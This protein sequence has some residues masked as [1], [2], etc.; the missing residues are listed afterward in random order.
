MLSRR[1]LCSAAAPTLV[2][3]SLA[4]AAVAADLPVSEEARELFR[5]AVEHA[6]ADTRGGYEQAYRAFKAAYA[7]SPSWKILGN[8]GLVAGELER[9]GEAIE[10]YERYLSEG[11]DLEPKVVNQYRRRINAMRF[12]QAEVVVETAEPQPFWIVD[13]RRAPGEP[14]VVNRYGPFRREDSPIR[15]VLRAGDH[16][17][18]LVPQSGSGFEAW[19]V[20]LEPGGAAKHAFHALAADATSLPE[21]KAVVLGSQVSEPR[22]E[23]ASGRRTTGFV[24]LGAS[25]LATGVTVVALL[26]ANAAESDAEQ[27]WHTNCPFGLTGVPPCA[28]PSDDSRR[29]A[30]WRTGA[31]FG[32]LIAVGSGVAGTLVWPRGTSRTA[33]DGDEAVSVALTLSPSGMSLSGAF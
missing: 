14:P 22:T 27:S 4:A 28:E 8:I 30:N 10:A 17:V 11:S 26:K 2:A 5:E 25:A 16:F 1:R 18:R 29:A 7:D 21:P 32:S 33:D 3:L 19:A 31:L 12:Q 24:L 9:Y 13:E 15:L 23:A 6:R 20:A